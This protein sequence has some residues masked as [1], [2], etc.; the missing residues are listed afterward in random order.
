MIRIPFK[1]DLRADKREKQKGYI[2]KSLKGLHIL[3]VEE[4]NELNMEIAELM[5][6]NE[7]A[8]VTKDHGMDRRLWRYSKKA[9]RVK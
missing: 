5:F 8:V 2:R 7:G 3:L 6:R 4:D 9:D 1:I